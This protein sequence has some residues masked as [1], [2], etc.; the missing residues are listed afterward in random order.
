MKPS[1]VPA[2]ALASSSG[3][4]ASTADTSS[5]LDLV[6]LGTSGTPTPL[7]VDENAQNSPREL[8][9]PAPSEEAAAEGSG[10]KSAWAPSDVRSS[11]GSGELAAV[12]ALERELGADGIEAVRN[13]LVAGEALESWLIRFLKPQNF[14]ARQA[15]KAV[16]AHLAW[17]SSM[18][19]AVLADLSPGEICG[20]T[21]ELLGT[22]M[23]T[24]HQ[25]SD[26]QGRPIVF[27]HYGKFRFGPVLEAGVTVEKILQL[28]IRNSERTARLCGEQSG[29]LGRDISDALIIMDTEGFDPNALR[30]KAAFEWARGMATIDQEQYPERMGQLL[31]INAPS[32]MYYFYKTVSWVLSE[33]ARSRVRIFG[34][35]ETWE[36]ALLELV[37]ASELPLQYGGSR[38]AVAP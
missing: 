26:R 4:L 35:R 8:D 21:E 25:G 28:H 14:R 6:S 34:G 16:R 18:N 37:D 30:S 5:D 36:P 13:I 27:S 12:Q 31:I 23:P 19:V 20:C 15:A 24:W 2:D 7:L 38:P 10:I 22:Y 29:K 32:S 33:R 3:S 11:L 9:T 17:R 1:D